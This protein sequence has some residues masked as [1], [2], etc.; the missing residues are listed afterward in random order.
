MALKF[1]TYVF[2][3]PLKKATGFLATKKKKKMERSCGTDFLKINI[4]HGCFVLSLFSIS[5]SF[6]LFITMCG[7]LSLL[8]TFCISFL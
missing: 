5:L 4:D 2:A 7:F 6:L 1:Q 3:S 8:F